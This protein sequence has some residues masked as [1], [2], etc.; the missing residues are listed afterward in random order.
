[1]TDQIKLSSSVPVTV[2][3]SGADPDCCGSCPFKHVVQFSGIQY[4]F[5]NYSCLLFSSVCS[6]MGDLTHRCGKC[7]ET[8]GGCK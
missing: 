5:R 6:T 4:G 2:V 7:I 3:V 8:F 1:M